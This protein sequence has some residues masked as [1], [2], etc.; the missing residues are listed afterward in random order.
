MKETSL[1]IA[2]KLVYQTM[3]P[4][5]FEKLY[6]DDDDGDMMTID[7]LIDNLTPLMK[8]LKDFTDWSIFSSLMG[9]VL[10]VFTE[11]YVEYLSFYLITVTH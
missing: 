7:T 8:D 10:D 9:A 11:C 3:K 5:I 1:I 4:M 6:F 2:Y